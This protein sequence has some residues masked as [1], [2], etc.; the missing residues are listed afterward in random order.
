MAG[1]LYLTAPDGSRIAL[2]YERH[3]EHPSGDWSWI[4]RDANGVEGILTFGEQAVFGVVPHG[5]GDTLRLTTNA[6]Q[7]WMAATDRSVLS[8]MQQ[9]INAGL[10]GPDFRIPERLVDHLDRPVQPAYPVYCLVRQGVSQGPTAP[11]K[12]GSFYRPNPPGFF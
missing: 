9:R 12:I 2:Q 5:E 1:T 8:P 6:G 4:G 10:T 3:V 7:T 11:A